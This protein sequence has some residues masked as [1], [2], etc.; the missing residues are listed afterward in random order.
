MDILYPIIH[1]WVERSLTLQKDK[2]PFSEKS[3]PRVKKTTKPNALLRKKKQT[4]SPLEDES[5]TKISF[6]RRDF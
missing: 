2:R 3:R 1:F 4:N 6:K 5:R